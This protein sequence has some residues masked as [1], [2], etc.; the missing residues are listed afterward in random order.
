MTGFG[1]RH[2]IC[3]LKL[4]SFG[5]CPDFGQKFPI[6]LYQ[7]QLM[8]RPMTFSIQLDI[9]MD[10]YIKELLSVPILR[11]QKTPKKLLQLVY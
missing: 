5:S 7:Q 3:I 1:Q 4:D 10:L 6:T 11:L 2:Q 8:I 9:T